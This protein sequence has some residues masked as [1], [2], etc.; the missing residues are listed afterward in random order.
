MNPPANAMSSPMGMVGS[1][2]L[3]VNQHP[4]LENTVGDFSRMANL[5]PPAHGLISTN[6]GPPDAPG[7]ALAGDMPP[8][9]FIPP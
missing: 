6:M 5:L 7:S 8:P 9:D 2:G 4:Q 3:P 1:N